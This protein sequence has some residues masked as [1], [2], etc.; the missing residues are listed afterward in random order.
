MGDTWP[1]A[2]SSV[3]NGLYLHYTAPLDA[4]GPA[5]VSARLIDKAG[6]SRNDAAQYEF[7]RVATPVVEA[8]ISED[9]DGTL[10]PGQ[11]TALRVGFRVE[12]DQPSL[13]D[14]TAQTIFATDVGSFVWH[15]L[16]GDVFPIFLARDNLQDVELRLDPASYLVL[17]GG[18]TWASDG[19]T[20]LQPEGLFRCD[21]D[22]AASNGSAVFFCWLQQRQA[23]GTLAAP[24]ITVADDAD[25]DIQVTANFVAAEGEKFLINYRR[26]RPAGWT[27]ATWRRWNYRRTHDAGDSYFGAMTLPVGEKARLESVSLQRANEASGTIRAKGSAVVELALRD[28]NGNPAAIGTVSSITVTATAGTLG[29][30]YCDGGSACSI[31]LAEGSAFRAAVA[32]NPALAAKIPITFT[33]PDES[34]TSSISATVVD[35]EGGRPATE[36]I[37]IAYSSSAS[38]IMLGSEMARVLAWGTPDA[39]DPATADVNEKD[40]RDVAEISVASLDRQ[41]RA[42]ELP[43]TISA[44][45]IDPNGDE[46]GSGATLTT[47]CAT[48]GGVEDRSDCKFVIDVNADRASPLASGLYTLRASFGGETHEATFTVAGAPAAITADPVPDLPALGETFSWGVAVADETGAPAAD[49][50]S[51]RFSTQAAGTG[52][53]PLLVVSPAGGAAKSKNGRAEATFTVIGWGVGII[54]IAAGSDET[55][56]PARQT[57]VVDAGQQAAEPAVQMLGL[58]P[59]ESASDGD[60]Q[61]AA[62]G[63]ASFSGSSA[64]SASNLL[65]T[66]EGR[67]SI[68]VWNGRRWIRYAVSEDGSAVPGSIDFT[69]VPGDFVWLGE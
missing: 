43:R 12:I 31:T 35:V 39:D 32:E 13:S 30:A 4:D 8:R 22:E 20:R 2:G 19:S 21:Y 40:D 25:G 50:T 15:I 29:G 24:Q 28:Q 56:E 62:S 51:V 1:I 16:A 61:P 34:G 36:S 33:A 64:T 14:P 18:A 53:E 23:D 17:A 60:E 55:G 38:A 27:D 45:L 68:H 54:R 65:S 49:G 58:P 37:E 47:A 11:T 9:A 26:E 48:V 7:S 6:T 3:T 69:L 5:I 10:E 52:T 42:A 59:A 41:G 44:R 46:V 67:R 63:L 66:L 57:V